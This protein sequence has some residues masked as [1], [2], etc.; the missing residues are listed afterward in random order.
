MIQA[1]GIVIISQRLIRVVLIIGALFAFIIYCMGKIMWIRSS[2]DYFGYGWDIKLWRAW[3]LVV[4]LTTRGID[5]K[6][7]ISISWPEE[8]RYINLTL[9]QLD[10]TLFFN[11]DWD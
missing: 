5:L 3:G 6:A 1:L 2:H 11:T 7:G 4:L 8:C 9:L 10:V